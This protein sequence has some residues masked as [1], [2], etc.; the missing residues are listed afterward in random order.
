MKHIFKLTIIGILFFIGHRLDAQEQM[1]VGTD[2]PDKSAVLD[3]SST[4]QGILIPR[5]NLTTITQDIDGETGQAEGLMVYNNGNTLKKGFYFWNGTEWRTLDDKTAVQPEISELLCATASIEPATFTLGV[6]F[7]GM[8]RVNY[9]GGNGGSF[10][11]G[12]PIPSTGNTGLTATLKQGELEYGT[13]TLVYDVVGTPSASSPTGAKF[14]ISFGTASPKSCTVTVGESV[15]ALI[16]ED[17]T[18]GPLFATNDNGFAGYHRVITSPNGKYSVRVFIN[19]GGSLSASDLQIRSNNDAG[20]KIMWNGAFAWNGGSSAQATNE[21]ILPNAGVWY[22]NSGATATS[23]ATAAWGDPDVYYGAPEQR[24]YVWTSHDLTD[25]TT[26][27][28]K[29]MLGAPSPNV[30]ASSSTVANTKAYLK[31]TQIT[32]SN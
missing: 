22:G 3:V 19:N 24:E 5:I 17:A 20:V 1:G 14:N 18:L 16:E 27:V 29:F 30:A 9:K 26:Y 13:G 11:A 12:V 7:Q 23:S 6:P 31:I 21:L 8:M 2:T 15:K 28:V 10:P 4:N 25:Q 32:A